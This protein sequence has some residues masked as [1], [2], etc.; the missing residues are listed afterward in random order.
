M[1]EYTLKIKK[2]KTPT[3]ANWV[4]TIPTEYTNIKGRVYNIV[5]VEDGG[6]SKYDKNG[7]WQ[8]NADLM[9]LINPFTNPISSKPVTETKIELVYKETY[10]WEEGS[11]EKMY[12][13]FL[14]DQC[15]KKMQT[16]Y[17]ELYGVD[18]DLS[19]TKAVEEKKV[20][21]IP[22]TEL[23]LKYISHVDGS[24]T[25]RSQL[26]QGGVTKVTFEVYEK[27]GTGADEKTTLLGKIDDL[28][29]FEVDPLTKK[30]SVLLSEINNVQIVNSKID[31]WLNKN[32]DKLPKDTKY[33][34]YE[35]PDE[36]KEIK[37]KEQIELDETAW[38]FPPLVIHGEFT[39]DVQEENL[40]KGVIFP[41]KVLEIIG[42]GEIKET[43]IDE[44]VDETIDEEI[45]EEYLEE[46][47]T[48]MDELIYQL[49]SREY[50]IEIELKNSTQKDDAIVGGGSGGITVD[51]KAVTELVQKEAIL[52]IMKDLIKLGGFTPE[53]AAGMC[54]NIK[55][56]SAFSCWN[57]ENGCAN[58]R[59][60]GNG[61]DRWN[62]GKANGVN[63]TSGTKKRDGTSAFRPMSGIGL[64]QWT[65]TRRANMERFVGKWLKDNNINARTNKDVIGLDTDPGQFS[66]TPSSKKSKG[67]IVGAYGGPGDELE[68]YLKTIPKLFEAQSAFLQH[69][70]KSMTVIVK[71]LNGGAL[72]GN[73]AKKYSQGWLINH[74]GGKM[75]KT[76]EGAAECIVCDFEVPAPITGSSQ[77]EYKELIRVRSTN[78]KDC[79]QTWIA[80]G[81]PR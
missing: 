69:E 14:A 37:T 64:A 20:D 13:D 35:Y 48:A 8:A 66:G 27:S 9:G 2:I 11:S 56:E 28:L 3:D 17:K 1:A 21:D 7:Y 29:K 45:D 50:N 60:S 5:K 77:A 19:Y 72:S 44:T 79:Y 16:R 76:V 61:T 6:K 31:D 80:A 43:P 41:F 23:Y 18:I 53:Q 65:F 25:S 47:S 78:A 68:K 36:K 4:T 30:I 39:F 22:P 32:I 26:P 33:G 55:A 52:I 38:E 54:G 57:V 67:D 73:T 46:D 15:V 62:V 63:Y 59:P 71:M 58:M 24:N 74:T 75:N 34:L 10:G 40:F 42:V 51:G 70:L 49:E 81:S 12:F